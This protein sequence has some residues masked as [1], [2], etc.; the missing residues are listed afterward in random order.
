M[1]SFMFMFDDVPDPVW[2][3]SIGKCA[4]C[5]PMATSWAASWIAFAMSFGM[6]PSWPLTVAAT[7]LIVARAPI[8]ARSIGLPEIGKFSTARCVWAPH[9]A[10]VGT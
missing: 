4:S 10:S 1:T 9:N 7:P 8:S 3:T 6:T 2:N 5:L